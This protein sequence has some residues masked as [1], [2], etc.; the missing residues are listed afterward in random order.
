MRSHPLA[1]QTGQPGAT[2]A[3]EALNVGSPN[4]GYVSVVLP[5]GVTGYGVF[6]QSVPGT[7]DQE[8]VVPLTYGGALNQT[9]V[10]DETISTT[11]VAI[12]NPS[13]VVAT[14]TI[15]VEDNNGNVIG[16][17]SPPIVLQPFNKTEAVLRTLPG[18]NGMA[19]NQGIAQF[20]VT[21]GQ[22]VVLG[23]R[24]KGLALTSIP[25]VN[26]KQLSDFTGEP[27]F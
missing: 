17:S 2:T 20:T 1:I 12:V 10:Y 26:Q 11:A 23:L 3:I 13:S 27:F 9:L 4:Q 18:L 25:A 14:I 7:T 22:V 16:T 5:V 21:A 15:T 6:R 8:A 19:N 24:A